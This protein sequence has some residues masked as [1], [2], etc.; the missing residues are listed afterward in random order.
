[1]GIFSGLYTSL[2]NALS[3]ILPGGNMYYV[4]DSINLLDVFIG[5][6]VIFMLVVILTVERG[7]RKAFIFTCIFVIFLSV[8]GVVNRGD[9]EQ[10]TDGVVDASE[11]AVLRTLRGTG[12]TLINVGD[13]WVTPMMI[14]EV[15]KVTKDG[16]V[17]QV[18][19]KSET[20][21]LKKT[22]VLDLNGDMDMLSK[23]KTVT[24]MD[25]GDVMVVVGSAEYYYTPVK[26]HSVLGK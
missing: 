10:V 14:T 12:D 20:L 5:C 24:T 26:L 2:Y 18:N 17:V 6:Y 15:E 19:Q 25:N 7:G 1:M 22:N 21:S 11:D 23:V 9:I 3:S 4:T 13:M 16:F 8:F